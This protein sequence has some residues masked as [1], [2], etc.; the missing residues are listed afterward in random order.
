MF[1]D[2]S[3]TTQATGATPKHKPFDPDLDQAR[4]N[5]TLSELYVDFMKLHDIRLEFSPLSEEGVCTAD[6]TCNPTNAYKVRGALVSADLA[7]KDG[8]TT[9]VTASAGNH[10]AGLAY[11]ARQ[12]GMRALI[13]V[14]KNAPQV[15]V[16]TIRSFGA[17]VR[18]VG[19][20]FDACLQE[21]RRDKLVASG[22]ATFVHPF[23]DRA[24]VAGQGTIGFELFKHLKS[25]GLARQAEKVRVVLPIGGGGL[26][27]GVVSVLKTV[28]P[29]EFPPLEVVGVVD[30]SS[31][32]SLLAMLRGRPVRAL[33]DTIADGTK[34]EVVGRNFLA[35]AHLLDGLILLPH[36]ELVG[37]MRR[38]EQK[39]GIRLEGAGA[40]ALGGE[41]VIRRYNLLHDPSSVV[42]VTLLTGKN[43]DCERFEAEVTAGVR[44]DTAKN[45]RQ[46][47]DVTIPEQPGQLLKF[48]EVVKEY[49]IAGLTYMRRVGAETGR[50]RV[51]FEVAHES[52][53]GLQEAIQ[54]AF[55]DSSELLRGQQILHVGGGQG[56]EAGTEKLIRL[57]DAPGSFLKCVRELHERND[58]GQVDFLFYRKPAK[59]GAHAQVVMGQASP[60]L[61]QER[62]VHRPLLH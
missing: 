7:K 20:S 47:F 6:A 60:L 58:L 48:L 37:A 40:L 18:L 4:R 45:D 14:P 30:E 46:G 54:G 5:T 39:T 36:D 13:Y 26:A 55:S 52:R 8:Q 17:E 16:E 38:H 32:A 43:I 34:V 11:A 51:E 15:K 25:K 33:T 2:H 50:L 23:D 42:S 31:P 44:M 24:V 19:D 57:D 62:D 10:G 21:A 59:K 53:L 22:A 35:V 29:K 9:L 56:T 61:E 1:K 12:L 27:A 41:E 28:W 49:N 3:Q